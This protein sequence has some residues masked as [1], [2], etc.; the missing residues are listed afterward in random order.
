MNISLSDFGLEPWSSSIVR[1]RYGR[2]TVLAVGRVPGTYRYF[3]VCSCDCDAPLKRYRI[4]KLQSGHT[5][6]C[7]CAQREA[8]TKHGLW[9]HPLYSIW[10][11]AMQRCYYASASR[12]SRYGGRGIRV[13]DRWHDVSAFVE[14]MAPT[15]W[16]G[17]SLD[18]IDCDGHYEP[19]NCRWVELS[20][21]ATNKTTTISITHQG[22]TLRLVEWAEIVGI[23]YGTLWDRFVKQGWS[24]SRTLTTP[25]MDAQSR[26][27]LAR[28]AWKP[29]K[30]EKAL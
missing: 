3:A 27:A 14:D 23:P 17:A 10:S 11:H 1:D 24:V 25:P 12:F 22:R 15:Y 26:C 13:C 7:G 28:A 29:R 30:R 21:Q 9:D 2:L 8:T 20:A 16:P 6:S 19:A 18:R 4:D 5:T